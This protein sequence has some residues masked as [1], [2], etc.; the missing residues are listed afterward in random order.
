[1]IQSHCITRLLE[2]QFSRVKII[3]TPNTAMAFPSK[4]FKG[5]R[6][7]FCFWRAAL[8]HQSWF[9]YSRLILL[10]LQDPP[11]S[12]A[13]CMKPPGKRPGIRRGGDAL[14]MA[15]F[16]QLLSDLNLPGKWISP[17]PNMGEH[18]S[19]GVPFPRGNVYSEK[20][21]CTSMLRVC[22]RIQ[23]A[24]SSSFFQS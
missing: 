14:S 21:L 9:V 17:P 20:G 4:D 13:L 6:V 8:W 7:C 12:R 18:T 3:R 10:D 16:C 11:W 23:L 5:I 19:P 1:M 24:P 22:L 15:A 2:K